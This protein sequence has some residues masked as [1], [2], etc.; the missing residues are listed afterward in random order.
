MTQPVRIRSAI[1]SDSPAVREI[2]N[3]A[4]RESLAI[5]TSREQTPEEAAAW[6]EPQVARGTAL[7]AVEDTDSD[8]RVLGFAVATPWRSYE[9]YAR[10]VEDSVYLSPAAQGHGTGGRLLDALV[11]ACQRAGD[12]TIVAAIE[13]GNT[14]SVRM[15]Q[16]HG[17]TVVGTIPQAGE[18]LGQVLDLTLMSR[19]LLPGAAS[20]AAGHP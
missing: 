9:G 19:Q 16:R 12:R 2:R 5:W 15:H 4:V 18:K 1:M 17:F 13:A 6:L 14:V 10:T 20:A 11:T 8:S 7:V 3:R